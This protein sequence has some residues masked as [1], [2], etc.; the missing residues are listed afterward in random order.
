METFDSN[1]MYLSRIKG[2]L[3]LLDNTG[4]FSDGTAV[5]IVGQNTFDICNK[6]LDDVILVDTDDICLAIKDIYDDTRSIMEPAGA[7]SLAGLKKYA[8]KYNLV[9]KKMV[10]ILSGA[11]MDFSKL[12]FISDRTGVK[13]DREALLYI[14]IPEKPGTFLKMYQQIFPRNVLEF[15]YRYSGKENANIFIVIKPI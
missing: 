4:L 13:S 3:Q 8:A 7:L 2:R 12:R 1:S 14:S 11:N 6:Y 5:K 15:S 9:D 10:S